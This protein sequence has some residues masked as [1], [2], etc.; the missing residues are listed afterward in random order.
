MKLSTL[1]S[2]M[3]GIAAKG[4]GPGGITLTQSKQTCADEPC[5]NGGQCITSERYNRGFHCRCPEKF[6]GIFCDIDHPVVKCVDSSMQVSLDKQMVTEHGLEDNLENIGFRGEGEGCSVR[7]DG[8]SYTLTIASPFSQ[9]GT[10]V[11]HAGDD[12]T[13]EN[14]VVWKHTRS[15]TLPNESAVVQQLNLINFSCKYEDKY[16]LHLDGPITP[17]VT[18]VDAKTGFGDF[19]VNLGLY[20]DET[21]LTPYQENPVVQISNDVCVQLELTNEVREDL[22]LTANECW[23]S[24]GPNGSGERHELLIN[25]CGNKDDPSMKVIQNGYSRYVQYCFEMFKW[26]ETMDQVYLNCNVEVCQV[27]GAGIHNNCVCRAHEDLYD[28]YYYVN[29]YYANYIDN[30]YENY[31]EY[32]EDGSEDSGERK[33][34][35]VKKS[36]RSSEMNNSFNATIS[37]KLAPELTEEEKAKRN[38]VTRKRAGEISIT[39]VEVFEAE[40]EEI[41][42]KE[43]D[44]IIMMIAI[45]LIVAT[46][47]L[48]ICIGIYVQCRRKYDIQRNKIRE[49]R[50]VKEFYNGVLK[51]Y[52]HPQHLPQQGQEQLPSYTN[53]N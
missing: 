9:C 18:T 35:S 6:T 20:Q 11:S 17:A 5:Q 13:Y 23:A 27:D 38:E 19:T 36:R 52:H 31:V 41:N 32:Q 49:M 4:K 42:S 53:T 40:I 45:A 39:D 44:Q 33:K 7:D 10:S 12:Y 21:F 28:Q 47:A 29:Y 2:V 22:V 25:R 1:F 14:A 46:I 51:P 30:L 8:D 24:S 50:K 16:T 34:R 43:N 48:G 15:S 37:W 3:G 26:Q